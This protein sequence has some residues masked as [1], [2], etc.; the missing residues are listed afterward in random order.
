[1]N[2]V[3]WDGTYF[4]LSSGEPEGRLIF[5]EEY[6]DCEKHADWREIESGTLDVESGKLR[7]VLKPI[8]P[9]LRDA[10]KDFKAAFPYL[11]DGE[12][13]VSKNLEAAIN[14]ELNR[15]SAFG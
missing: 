9:S 12:L 2:R 10:W 6:I 3:R 5:S 13:D 8:V 11:T 7:L 15:P 1:M 14:R 4:R